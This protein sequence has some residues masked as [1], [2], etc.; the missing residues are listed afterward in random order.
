MTKWTSR[1]P[2]RRRSRWK[3][4]WT[5]PTLCRTVRSTSSTTRSRNCIISGSKRS[6]RSTTRNATLRKSAL[7]RIV[8]LSPKKFTTSCARTMK[9][10]SCKRICFGL[11]WL[12]GW[13]SRLDRSL[14]LLTN[15]LCSLATKIWTRSKVSCSSVTSHLIWKP[16]KGSLL[17]NWKN[18]EKMSRGSG[19]TLRSW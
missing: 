14:I 18:G 19:S 11:S 16:S 1:Q 7:T 10:N 3:S 13:E 6:C 15:C 12:N 17:S 5:T 9:L 4:K 2:T 8:W